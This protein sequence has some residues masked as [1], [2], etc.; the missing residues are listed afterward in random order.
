MK[1]EK[2]FPLRMAYGSL[3]GAV[4]GFFGAGGGMVCVPLLMK[5]GLPRKEAHS[6]AVAVIFPITVV[7]AASYLWQGHMKLTEVFPYLLGGFLGAFLGTK[8]IQKISPK[9][10]KRIFGLFVIWAG[11]RLLK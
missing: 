7:S 9:W 3:I 10:L 2:S 4:N 5:L 6:N 11:W 8:I 1:K